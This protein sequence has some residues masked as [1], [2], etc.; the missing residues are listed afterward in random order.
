MT[1]A[2]PSRLIHLKQLGFSPRTV[3]DIGAHHGNWTRLAQSIWPTASFFMI[4]ANSDH[5]PPLSQ[6]PSSQFAIALLGDG[7]KP[8]VPFYVSSNRLSAG[9]SIYLEQT[10]VFS[11]HKTRSLPMTTLDTLVSQSHL[12]DIDFI[13]IDTQGSELDIISGG[14]HTV[15][16]TEFILLE[17]QILDYNLNAPHLEAVVARMVKIGFC[18]F[19]V[20]DLHYLPSGQLFQLDLIFVKKDSRF[21][22][23][24]QLI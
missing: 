9:N 5:A 16:E 4:E 15:S 10:F 21:L 14:R 8:A 3:L 18:P 13:K 7:I 23:H 11:R 22:P 20:V 6:V 12:T 1:P 19:D 24:G 17:T 2:P